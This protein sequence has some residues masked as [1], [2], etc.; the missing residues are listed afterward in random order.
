MSSSV[1]SRRYANIATTFAT[2]KY[3][4]PQ[5]SRVKH[6]SNLYVR[7]QVQATQLATQAYTLRWTDGYDVCPL[8]EPSPCPNQGTGLVPAIRDTGFPPL[9]LW[10]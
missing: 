6:P 5:G 7:P 2:S 3:P 1:R 4:Q 8:P 10:G 9:S